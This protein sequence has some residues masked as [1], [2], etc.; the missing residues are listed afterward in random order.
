M[1]KFLSYFVRGSLLLSLFALT[2]SV[3]AQAESGSNGSLNT[4]PIQNLADS[5]IGIINT[6]VVPVVFAIAFIVFIWGVFNY[7]IAG[8]ANEEK[9]AEGTKFVFSAIIGFVVM[10]SIWG[11]VNLVGSSLPGMVNTRPGLP[12]FGET[13]QTQSPQT[14][15]LNN[16][17]TNS[18]GKSSN[19]GAVQLGQS[20]GASCSA[21]V[22]CTDGM[23]C[24]G[25][26]CQSPSSAT[27]P[28]DLK[29]IPGT[30]IPQNLEG[31][32]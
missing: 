18:S 19:N 16:K 13:S 7:F 9:R 23:T 8:G 22:G 28:T 10:V 2:S 21:S 24:T 3:H 15:N 1:N 4:A 29:F 12:T 26:K 27:S 14:A 32:Y 30:N 17:A 25:G 20:I 31:L 6:V 5:L 11:I